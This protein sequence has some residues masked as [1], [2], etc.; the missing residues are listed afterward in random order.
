M[1][2]REEEKMS[3]QITPAVILEELE[4]RD[5]KITILEAEL[6]AERE[7]VKELEEYIARVFKRGAMA[8]PNT[9]LEL[10]R[11]GKDLLSREASDAKA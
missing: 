10:L 9:F 11:E 8:N 7:R 5:S 3:R 2:L 1:N 6:R 4:Q